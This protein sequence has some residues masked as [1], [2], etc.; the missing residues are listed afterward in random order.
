MVMADWTQTYRLTPSWNPESDSKEV[1][2]KGK[3][4][5]KQTHK[6]KDRKRGNN[7]CNTE[8]AGKQID[9]PSLI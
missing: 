1:F 2:F 3:Q 9:M 5:N 4:T 8:D 7:N 6:V